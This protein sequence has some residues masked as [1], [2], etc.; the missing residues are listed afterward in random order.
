MRRA[1]KLLALAAALLLAALLA[2]AWWVASS[3]TGLQWLV[4]KAVQRSHG[5]LAIEGVSGTLLGRMQVHRLAYSTPDVRIILEDVALEMQRDASLHGKL[6]F[7]A[8]A[9]VADIHSVPSGTPT[10]PPD[11]LALPFAVEIKS[12]RI[13]HARIEDQP[14]NNLAFDYRG[15][16]QPRG[17]S[18]SP[19]NSG[20]SERKN[21]ARTLPWPGTYWPPMRHCMGQRAERLPMRRRGSRRLTR[22]GC[23]RCMC[24]ANT[25]TWQRSCRV[26]LNRQSQLMLT[27]LPPG[28]AGPPARSQ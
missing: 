7:T 2:G 16:P 21:G 6:A 13:A 4:A 20:L 11:S 1:L 25:S 10:A 19:D 3:P 22:A 18:P 8:E 14:F 28:M 26:L 9:A 17:L 23:V 27:A 24:T 5:T 12:G 15:G